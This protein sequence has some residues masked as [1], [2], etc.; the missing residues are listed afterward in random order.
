MV[1]LLLSR[2][3]IYLS[4]RLKLFIIL[5]VDKPVPQDMIFSLL[6]NDFLTENFP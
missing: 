5:T 4:G 1:L 2:I 6:S 3:G